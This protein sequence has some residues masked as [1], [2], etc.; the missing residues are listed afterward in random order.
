MGGSRKEEGRV[1]KEGRVWV[2][3]E[4]CAPRQ[5]L[6]GRGYLAPLQYKPRAE[7]HHRVP[8]DLRKGRQ[9]GASSVGG[10]EA[11]PSPRERN[12]PIPAA[13]GFSSGAAVAPL[14]LQPLRPLPW[15]GGIAACS[16]A[17]P[18]Y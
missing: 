1:G 5:H 9:G 14:G 15:A 16:R 6:E 18:S 13:A 11:Y 4:V 3:E 7:Q 2:K 8:P 10:A 12:L 17:Q